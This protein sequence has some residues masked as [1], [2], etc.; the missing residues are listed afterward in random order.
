MRKIKEAYCEAVLNSLEYE[1]QKAK[2]RGNFR[3][4]KNLKRV[5]KEFQKIKRA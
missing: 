2:A 5:K 3:R 1:I 4:V